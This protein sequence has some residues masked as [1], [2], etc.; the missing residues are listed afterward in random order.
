VTTTKVF[1]TVFGPRTILQDSLW[2]KSFQK[3][4]QNKT[5]T[6]T[7]TKKPQRYLKPFNYAY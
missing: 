2:P 6:I 5:K 7:K 1:S 4:K 3:K